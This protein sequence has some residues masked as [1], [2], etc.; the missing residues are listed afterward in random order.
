MC[1]MEC[2]YLFIMC[3]EPRRPRRGAP[4][5]DQD[6]YVYVQTPHCPAVPRR[7]P[8]AGDPPEIALLNDFHSLGANSRSCPFLKKMS[9]HPSGITVRS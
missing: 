2:L 6:Q 5:A 8:E 1:V 9:N 3:D 7:G 4:A